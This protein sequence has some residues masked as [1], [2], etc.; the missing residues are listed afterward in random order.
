TVRAFFDHAFAAAEM[1][2]ARLLDQ[3][4]K[5]RL[6]KTLKERFT[7][8]DRQRFIMTFVSRRSNLALDLQGSHRI[9]DSDFAP[10]EFVPGISVNGVAHLVVAGVSRHREL[11][12]VNDR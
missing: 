1:V 5:L 10:P 6:G 4:I 9:G 7:A 8:Q 11:D 2:E 12:L 3:M